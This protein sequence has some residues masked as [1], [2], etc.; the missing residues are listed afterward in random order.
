M[1]APLSVEISR[2]RARHDGQCG[3]DVVVGLLLGRLLGAVHVKH[4]QLGEP[5]G[6]PEPQAMWAE[7]AVGGNRERRLYDVLL[8]GGHARHGDP[9]LL[10]EEFL[11]LVELRARDRDLDLASLLSGRRLD[12]IE[13]R[14]GDGRGREAE[15][16]HGRESCGKHGLDGA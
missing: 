3:G 1:I 16:E 10:E 2:G 6:R 13:G 14:G 12:A 11:G 5:L 9:P 4:P 8:F 7:R 15:E